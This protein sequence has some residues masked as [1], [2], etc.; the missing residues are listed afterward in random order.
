M[1][2]VCIL[3][4]GALASLSQDQREGDER[5]SEHLKMRTTFV[6]RI[7]QR[8]KTNAFAE[9]VDLGGGKGGE[10]DGSSPFG[11]NIQR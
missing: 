9:L 11:V 3:A 5:V 2:Q 10:E 1:L 8:Y 4:L 6:Q 7:N